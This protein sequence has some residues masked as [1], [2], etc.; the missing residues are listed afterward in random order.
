MYLTN[1]YLSISYNQYFI[2]FHYTI[3]SQKELSTANL[4]LPKFIPVVNGPLCLKHNKQ[5]CEHPPCKPT[6]IQGSSPLKTGVL[7]RN[8]GQDIVYFLIHSD[9]QILQILRSPVMFNFI[10]MKICTKLRP[11]Y[12]SILQYP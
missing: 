5:H 8:T 2:L 9:Y 7:F 3:A 1:G 4:V 11:K 12:I 6:M 10:S